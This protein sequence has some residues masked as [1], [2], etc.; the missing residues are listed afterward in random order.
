MTIRKLL[1]GVLLVS[2]AGGVRSEALEDIRIR[3]VN[4][5]R[6]E[7]QQARQRQLPI[8]LMFAADHCAY[9][10]VVEDDFLEPMLRSGE[11]EDKVLIRKLDLDNYAQ[12]TDFDGSRIDPGELAGRYDI[13]VTPTLVFIDAEGR[14]L[15]AKM[16]GLTT[17]D[18]YGG[19]IDQAIETALERL[20]RRRSKNRPNH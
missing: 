6:A 2:A 13:S 8:L 3:E 11:Y 7:A 18:F 12:L 9:C 17:P 20:N 1:L 19:Y 10:H 5:L 4:D 15:A 14:Q 16:V